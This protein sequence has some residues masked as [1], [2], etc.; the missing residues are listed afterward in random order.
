MTTLAWVIVGM[1]VGWVAGMVILW[2]CLVVSAR[3]DRAWPPGWDTANGWT[4]SSQR[5]RIVPGEA[6]KGSREEEG[7]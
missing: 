6:D 4:Y 1:L 7:R 3:A 2:C 5:M